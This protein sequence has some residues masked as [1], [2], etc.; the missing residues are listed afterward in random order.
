MEILIILG[1][2]LVAGAVGMELGF[3]VG[4]NYGAIGFAIGAFLAAVAW[5]VAC[6]IALGPRKK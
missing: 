6:V 3:R 1:T 2:V 5:L 4:P